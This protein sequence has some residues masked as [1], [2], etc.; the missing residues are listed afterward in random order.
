VSAAEP[1]ERTIG[2]GERTI[3]SGERTIGSSE[4]TIGSSEPQTGPGERTIGPGERETALS[5]R[6]TAL[7]E[8]ETALSERETAD[9]E[10]PEQ[11][12]PGAQPTVSVTLVRRGELLSATMALLLAIDMFAL[13]WFGVAGVP[14]P[15]AA[16]PA[17]STAENA[18]DGLTIVRWVMLATVMVT[19]GSVVLHASQRAHGTKTDTSVAVT[20]VGVLTAAL[21]TY[22][23]L[24]SLP[25]PDE[26]IDQ[27]LGAALGLA[28]ALGI[29]LGGL[30]SIREQRAR[31]TRVLPRSGRRLAPR[32]RA[33]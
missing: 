29:A 17:L 1:S 22:R 25:A 28:C 14:D 19:L 27:K 2:S 7:S 33:R 4:R 8:R 10:R 6:E 30:E 9:G 18:W 31:A 32:R 20:V 3:G 24:I 16:R 26:V 15:S 5:E 13:K 12:E 21:L 23:V 11:T